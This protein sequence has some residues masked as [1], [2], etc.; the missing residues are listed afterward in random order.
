V[1]VPAEAG[2]GDRVVVI[3]MLIMLRMMAA[4]ATGFSFGVR[5]RNRMAETKAQ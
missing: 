2:G 4:M 5:D 1:P 3:V